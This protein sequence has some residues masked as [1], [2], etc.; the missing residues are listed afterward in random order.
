[1]N[2]IS[3]GMDD[4]EEKW[5]PNKPLEKSSPAWMWKLQRQHL[6]KG[7][8]RNKAGKKKGSGTTSQAPDEEGPPLGK[9][10]VEME[11]EAPLEK[12]MDDKVGEVE[13]KE[14][15]P[16]E[17]EGAQGGV[18]MKE[19]TPLEKG[20]DDLMKGEGLSMRQEVEKKNKRKKIM[21]DYRNTLAINDHIMMPWSVGSKTSLCIQ[22]G[23]T[24]MFDD[25]GD[26][27]QEAVSKGIQVY[28]IRKTMHWHWWADKEKESQQEEEE[29]EQKQPQQCLTFEKGSVYQQWQQGQQQGQQEL[30]CDEEGPPLQKGD[31]EMEKEAPLEKG[32]DDKVGEVEMKEEEPV[33]K[34]G[35]Q[36]GVEM[37]EETPLEKGEGEMK[38]TPGTPLEKGYLGMH[39]PMSLFPK[40]GEGLFIRQEVEERKKMKKIMVDYHN[41]LAINDHISQESSDA[42]ES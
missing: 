11:K 21:V 33:E 2:R 1:M 28:P 25:A 36:G 23:C 24:I 5:W 10:D 37:K 31:E 42:L 7:E 6:A 17:K 29:A 15:E 3:F 22:H 9:G 14:E 8:N 39:Q 32:M 34:E 41:T 19:E 35:A 16:V 13:M 26:I 40:P 20:E 18:Q 4:A 27:L 30:A 38:G 12:G